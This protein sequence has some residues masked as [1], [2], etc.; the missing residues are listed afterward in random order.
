MKK[1]SQYTW[2]EAH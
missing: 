1:M 2:L